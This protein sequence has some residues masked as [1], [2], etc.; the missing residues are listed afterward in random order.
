MAEIMIKTAKDLTLDERAAW[1][2]L[3]AAA[4]ELAGP[5][6]SLGY[7][8]ALSEVRGDVRVVV[9]KHSGAPVAFL[10]LQLGLLGH[11]R[12]LGGPLSDHHA[13]V[14]SLADGD[15]LTDMLARARVSVF[16]FHAA[17]GVQAPFAELGGQPDGSW[18][19]GLDGGFDAWRSRRKKP[20]GNT[21]RT[22]LVAERKLAE[23]HGTVEFRFDDRSPR[24]LE[25]LIAWKSGQYRRT[26]H[27]DVFSVAWT[28]HL[29][30]QL[31]QS[32]S[33]SGARGVISS[34]TVDGQIAAV[35]FGIVGGGVM[36]YW[37]PA[38]DPAFQKEGS[39][40]ALLVRILEAAQDQGIREVHLGGGDYR[41]KVA[42]ADHQFPIV[43]GF[44]G[45]G[46]VAAAR[47]L[48]QATEQIAAQIRLGPLTDLPGRVFRRIDRI[49]GFRAA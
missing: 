21:L 40:N 39:G 17:L 14:G 13:I 28:R 20:G 25:A 32:G 42:L 29:V 18:V 38:Y 4:P 37:F 47:G 27:F 34:L 22:I 35:H 6:F 8:D 3:Q 9:K 45:T 15:E 33:E 36:H 41:Y 11:A 12:P 2:E 1:V 26:G 31:L 7:L 5:Y 48:A 30:E 23:R 19:I 10:P 46:A 24:A 44:A 49:A 43:S 16:D